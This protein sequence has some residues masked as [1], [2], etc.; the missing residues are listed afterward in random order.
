MGAILS[1]CRCVVKPLFYFVFAIIPV[2]LRPLGVRS[3]LIE[4]AFDWSK[5]SVPD[6][7]DGGSAHRPALNKYYSSNA[8]AANY[9]LGLM[10]PGQCRLLPCPL[11]L[12]PGKLR[13]KDATAEPV[14]NMPGP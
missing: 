7:Q 10:L 5:E 2:Y 4:I 6:G 13:W 11:A 1:R 14:E 3:S 8:R 9:Q 12:L